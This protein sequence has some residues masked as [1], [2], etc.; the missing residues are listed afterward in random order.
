MSVRTRNWLT[1]ASVLAAVFVVAVVIG[2]VVAGGGVGTARAQTKPAAAPTSASCEGCHA[3]I[4]PMHQNVDLGCVDCHGGDGTAK[5]KDKAHVLPRNKAL[6]KSSANPSS[7]YGAINLE[8]P[9]FIRFMNP[10]D[11]RVADKSCGDCHQPIVDA[12]RRSIMA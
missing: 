6:W 3:G 2:G 5:E 9:E 12:A 10:S 8:S 1:A 7:T 4:E 11:L